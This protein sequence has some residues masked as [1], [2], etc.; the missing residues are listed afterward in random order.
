M[1]AEGTTTTRHFPEMWAA[2][3]R[4]S[5]AVERI[6]GSEKLHSYVEELADRYLEPERPRLT[7]IQGGRDDAS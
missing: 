3:D 4:A 5:E 2:I 7:L 6:S 1:P